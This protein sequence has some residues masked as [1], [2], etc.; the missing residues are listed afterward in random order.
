MTTT[1]LIA[2]TN[3]T[4]V[5]GAGAGVPVQRAYSATMGQVIDVPGDA[6]GDAAA[7]AN[8]GFVIIGTS[9]PTS[10][11][12]NAANLKPGAVHI[13]T[14]LNAVVVSDGANWRSPITGALT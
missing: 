10:A 1:R 5:I 13:D 14:S 3:T 7:L 4:G 12:P 8:Q 11:R 6:T 2:T 9:G